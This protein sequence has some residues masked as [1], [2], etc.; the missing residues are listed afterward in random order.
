MS[1]AVHKIV[2]LID[3]DAEP[4][5]ITDIAIEAALEIA[6]RIEDCGLV[7]TVEESDVSVSLSGMRGEV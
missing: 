6:E 5:V 4:S 2:I 3:T 1:M 7:A